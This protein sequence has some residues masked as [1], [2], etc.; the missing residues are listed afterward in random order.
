MHASV[1]CH[2]LSCHFIPTLLSFI[3]FLSIGPSTGC[4]H[5]ETHERGPFL[6]MWPTKECIVFCPK[7]ANVNNY[8]Q[9]VHHFIFHGPFPS[10]TSILMVFIVLLFGIWTLVVLTRKELCK[11]KLLSF[12]CLWILFLGPSL[13]IDLCHTGF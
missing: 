8:Q 2:K 10:R 5:D 6:I 12:Y 3:L 7:L 4:T 9:L 11:L 13:L 1:S